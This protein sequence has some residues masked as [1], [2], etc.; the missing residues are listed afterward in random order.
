MKKITLCLILLIFGFQSFSQ[1]PPEGSA[2]YYRQKSKNQKKTAWILL[3]AGTVMAV[4]G[5]I[6]FNRS[7]NLPEH[8]TETDIFGFIMLAGIVSDLVSI[9]VFISSGRNAR[10]ASRVSVSTQ[11]IDFPRVNNSYVEPHPAI[12]IK[13]PF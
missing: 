10:R 8:Y 2:E 5:G 6:G 9:P 3:G 4:G 7:W 12:S 13:I 1:T 11:L